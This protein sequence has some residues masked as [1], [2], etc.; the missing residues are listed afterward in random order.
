MKKEQLARLFHE[1]TKQFDVDPS[2]SFTSS[3]YDHTIDYKSYERAEGVALEFDQSTRPLDGLL[4]ER[5][6]PKTF[7]DESCT[8]AQLESILS[9]AAITGEKFGNHVRAYPSAGARY[10]N[11]IYLSISDVTGVESGVYHFNIL[12]ERLERIRSN[13]IRDDIH[14][15]NDQAFTRTAPFFVILAS[16]FE[17]TT[18]KYGIRGY[19][20]AYL[21]AGHMLQNLLLCAEAI[22]LAGRP[23]GGFMEDTID[24]LLEL[25]DGETSVYLCAFGLPP[26][27]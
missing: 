12:E 24:D 15:M 26:E 5:R 2:Y 3:E 8:K 23:L 19:R 6:S 25:S 27:A 9:G 18:N 17:R 22:G 10:P 16:T 11:E 20:Y 14:A 7:A 21:E 1:N 13:P 4:T